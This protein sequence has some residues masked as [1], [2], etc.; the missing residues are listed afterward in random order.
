MGSFGRALEA[1]EEKRALGTLADGRRAHLGKSC[2]HPARDG[3]SL[4]QWAS[5]ILFPLTKP[6]PI[7]KCLLGIIA[8]PA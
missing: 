3:G 7:R 6:V 1:G 2:P 4:R 5:G 8:S